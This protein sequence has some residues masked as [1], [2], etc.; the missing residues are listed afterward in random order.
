[1]SGDFS[2]NSFDPAKA[3]SLV[4]LQQGR[5]LSDADFNEQGDRLRHARRQAV[6]AIIGPAGFPQG[7]A[8]FGLAANSGLPGLTLSAGEA[9]VGGRQ[10]L[11]AGA[12]E[13]A[14]RRK[15]GSGT[16]T[17]WVLESGP[18]LSIGDVLSKEEDGTGAVFRVTSV[19]LDDEEAIFQLDASLTPQTLTQAYLLTAL[20]PDADA[21]P[22]AN[23]RYLAAL[24]VWDASVSALDDPDLLE[25]AF[26][27]PDTST[28]D[29]TRWKVVFVTE[30]QLAAK[31]IG[32]APF[33]C[34]D[35]QGGLDLVGPRA[36]L[37]AR[38]TISDTETGPCTL[39]PD[40]GYR[41]IE[42]HL[43]RVEIHQRSG[44]GAPMYKWS[45][46]NGMHRT[47][48]SLIENDALVVDSIGRDDVTALKEGDWVEIRDEAALA[49]N[50]AGIFAR[51]GGITGQRV[52]IA[53]LRSAHDLSPML[54]GTQP[55]IAALPR[56]ATIQ[57]WEGGLPVE[58][59]PAAGWV[60]LELGVEVRFQAGA[61]LPGDFWTIP[62]RAL[63]GDVDWPEDM[64]TGAPL[65]LPP[66][67]LDRAF[68]PLGFVRR[69]GAGQWEVESDCREFFAPL[70]EQDQ[71]DFAGGDGQE[72]MPDETSPNARILLAEELKVSVTRGE[73]PVAGARIRFAV[74]Q[75]NGRLA[76][77]Q[78]SLVVPTNAS[79]VA[80]I[81]WQVDPVNTAQSVTA[82]RVDSDGQPVGTPIIFSATLSR[83]RDTS[84]DPSNTPEL[85]GALTVQEALEQLAQIQ[86][87]GCETHVITPATDW[88]AVLSGIAPGTNVNI[89]FAP[90]RYVT[91]TTVTLSKLG[92]VK[93][94]GSGHGVEILAT[95]SECAIKLLDCGNAV[96]RG[97]SVYA[98]GQATDKPQRE[99]R[100][101]ALTIIGSAEVDIADCHFAC[102]PGLEAQRTTLTVGARPDGDP[103]QP[104]KRVRIVN[105]TAQV[106]F[107]QE[108]F[109]VH[110][111]VDTIIADNTFSVLPIPDD[112]DIGGTG[113]V[114][115]SKSRRD[116]LMKALIGGMTAN[117]AVLG[118]EIREV[119]A[120]NLSFTFMS[121]IP[122]SE[123]DRAVKK[124]PPPPAAGRNEAGMEAYW[125]SLTEAVIEN[126]SLLP[127]FESGL[128][129][130]SNGM[131]ANV[132]RATKRNVL[133]LKEIG[134]AK[135]EDKLAGGRNVLIELGGQSV[136]FHSPV[137]NSEWQRIMARAQETEKFEAGARLTDYV[138]K[139]GQRL[140]EGDIKRNGFTDYNTWFNANTRS[141]ESTAL[142]GI[143][144]AGRRLD[145]V[146]IAG[147]VMRGFN[148]GIRVAVSHE[149]ES[150]ITG[151]ITIADN[152]LELT[153]P[154]NEV[155]WLH[156][157]YI[158]NVDRLMMSNN[159]L[160]HWRKP[161][162]HNSPFEFGVWVFGF[163]GKQ[164]LFK[165]NLIEIGKRGF[166]VK[167]LIGAEGEMDDGEK[168]QYHWLIAD[169]RVVDVRF[170]DS[171]NPFGI[172]EHRDNHRF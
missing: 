23:G 136:A 51:L 108:G 10:V 48:Y 57:R 163:L 131:P 8:G 121:A 42:N 40:A 83:A 99:H 14:I 60:E 70:T 103:M 142:H 67:G 129:S 79:G 55:N 134:V 11:C 123:W 113:N 149:E 158:G 75:G 139:T 9:F 38:A 81:G 114:K 107:E 25:V 92:H 105:C 35:V 146:R 109:L 102:G 111:A 20:D 47:R 135:R 98:L 76:G 137:R 58:A 119:R 128:K 93:L 145:S 39:P 69:Q 77:G 34:V 32:E 164:L 86:N 84:F 152:L 15:S 43:Y 13:L 172:M 150:F 166:R 157:I 72:A 64:V 132:N 96:V 162:H 46:D 78:A 165:D 160:L 31:G 101:G 37:A 44:G 104:M 106:G 154:G 110:D 159:R 171:T 156:G 94:N 68:A 6:T 65:D 151:D 50:N 161:D 100:L 49:N 71:V 29:C 66:Q 124:N 168:R 141:R 26:D 54:S 19:E 133:L 41:S 120:G 155:P 89:C 90:G 1:M 45:R 138:L 74:T 115:L 62:A 169:N 91:D 147:N 122:Q 21:L 125:K 127:S 53:E 116:Q 33:T 153:T 140:L 73:M 170:I 24:E 12:Q 28:R 2:R 80:S 52:A 88:V 117:D 143:V 3:Y 112:F 85:A 97:L 59:D 118:K 30:G 36:Q 22:T 82:T 63:T 144:C 5:L 126:P 95:K 148:T 18:A 16:A 17:K 27:G 56:A 87:G 61:M 4:R 7:N 167:K 130:I